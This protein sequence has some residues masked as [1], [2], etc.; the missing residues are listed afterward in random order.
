MNPNTKQLRKK[1]PSLFN[2]HNL[3]RLKLLLLLRMLQR[4][5]RDLTEEREVI[6]EEIIVKKERD[7]KTIVDS[8]KVKRECTNPSTKKRK[9]LLKRRKRI[10]VHLHLLLNPE[11]SERNKS[12]NLKIKDLSLLESQ[13]Q[14]LKINKLFTNINMV[15]NTTTIIIK[16]D[17]TDQYIE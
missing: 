6:E 8:K 7:L 2:K 15:K 12:V 9:V 4:D 3:N 5:R 10:T 1:Q 11:T 14:K 17:K 16:I 13:N